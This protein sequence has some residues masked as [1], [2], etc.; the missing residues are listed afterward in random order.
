MSG[1]NRF[2][3]QEVE[4]PLIPVV[5]AIEDAGYRIDK[6][7]FAGVARRVEA[8]HADVEGP[9]RVIAGA[10]FNPNSPKQ[11][12][13]LLFEKLKL[14]VG[15]RT[16]T[17]QPATDEATLKALSGRHEVVPL[18]LR[19][20]ALD[21]VLTTYCTIPDSAGEDGRL[22]V[23]FKQL[24]AETGRLTSSSVIQTLPKDDEFGLR[25]GFVAADGFTIAAADFNQQELRVLAAV[26]GDKNLKE[27][28]AAG[29]DLHGVAAVKVFGLDCTANEVKSRHKD[30]RDRVKAIQFGIIYGK[31][32]L[33]LAGDLGISREEADALL[34][35]YF[36]EFPAVKGF[37]DD[38]HNRLCADGFIDDLFGRRR[39][40]PDARLPRPRKKWER[41]SDAEKAVVGKINAA[42][43]A[44]QN[45][46]I[47]GASA[48]IT[49]LAMIRC[50][51]H[52]QAE[53]PR[54]QMILTLHDELQFEV[55]EPNVEHFRGELPELMC[56]LGL[57]RF[58]FDVPMA[59]ETKA[60][61]TWGDLKP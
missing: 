39:Y 61:P 21:K 48:T 30:A 43:R 19:W 55:P 6:Q 40:L 7:F 44:A 33:S 34:A 59:V 22:H 1:L 10:D 18:L 41:M 20:R 28:I 29:L 46:V 35:D 27:A 53:H 57:D 16:A 8:E 15:K 31:S 56:E 42:K 60:G 58:G 14:P 47:Q 5:A 17:D 24:G 25:K 32:A 2:L 13:K 50:H 36:R 54:I 4:F 3:T 45:F 12:A 26:S 49:K 51:R 9:I 37:I 23:E 38:A 52:I 11:V